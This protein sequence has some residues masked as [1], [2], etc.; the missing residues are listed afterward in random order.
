MVSLR[1]LLYQYVLDAVK[2]DENFFIPYNDTVDYIKYGADT[3][4]SKIYICEIT[5]RDMYAFIIIP[6]EFDVPMTYPMS[7]DEYT[8]LIKHLTID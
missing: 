2:S 4:E 8:N 3:Y 7:K 6:K 5:G 1:D